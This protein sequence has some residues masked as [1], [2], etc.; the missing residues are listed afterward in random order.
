MR[1]Y[2]WAASASVVISEMYG[3]GCDETLEAVHHNQ[4]LLG[5]PNDYELEFRN[6]RGKKQVK[7]KCIKPKIN[8]DGAVYNDILAYKEYEEMVKGGKY[9]EPELWETWQGIPTWWK[10]RCNRRNWW[11]KVK[12]YNP[13]G[14]C[15][16]V[17]SWVAF[18]ENNWEPVARDEGCITQT[19]I[20]KIKIKDWDADNYFFEELEDGGLKVSC[21]A[22]ALGGENIKYADLK[23][24][25]NA[26]KVFEKINHEWGN[27]KCRAAGTYED[28]TVTS[29]GLEDCPNPKDWGLAWKNMLAANPEYKELIIEYAQEASEDSV[30]NDI[31]YS[32]IYAVEKLQTEFVKYA[33]FRFS[34]EKEKAFRKVIKAIAELQS[35]MSRIDMD[36]SNSNENVR[37]K[38]STMDESVW[39]AV[40]MHFASD[41]VA[42]QL[43]DSLKAIMCGDDPMES[44]GDL[45]EMYLG[46]NN[47]LFDKLKN[48]AL[49]IAEKRLIFEDESDD[50]SGD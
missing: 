46:D 31:I 15:P 44:V 14:Y 11:T 28:R 40:E 50:N 42:T 2:L 48:Y 5:D 38:R 3:D 25:S 36:G 19:A 18:K 26:M 24:Y 21:K 49:G 4:K 7:I 12:K 10:L 13:V 37:R 47:Y 16:H 20:N 35:T 29:G 27:F 34:K 30:R 45:I 17:S 9:G 23:G 39:P 22:P 1:F 41:Q 43:F 33:D 6:T 32:I 8:Q